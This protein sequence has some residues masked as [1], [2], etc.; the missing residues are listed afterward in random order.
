VLVY[1][2][3]ADPLRF[4]DALLVGADEGYY[5][6]CR[7]MLDAR[8]SGYLR[9]DRSFMG[10]LTGKFNPSP[11]DLVFSKSG[12]LIGMMVNK[13]FCALLRSFSP[14][15][16]I[17]TGTHLNSDAIGMRLAAMQREIRELRGEMQ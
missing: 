13:Q 4:Q 8:N 9:M 14:T 15:A 16:T 7:F 3:T 10:R 2:L 11:G 6:E 1:R 5:G 12:D 17:P